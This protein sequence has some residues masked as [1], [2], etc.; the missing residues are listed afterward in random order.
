MFIQEADRSAGIKVVF[1]DHF[2]TDFLDRG[3]LVSFTGIMGTV[4]GQRVIYEDSE[5]T[6]DFSNREPLESLGMSNAAIQGWP[7]NPRQPSGPRWAGL[8]PLGLFV[9]VWGV[10]TSTGWA[11]EDGYYIYLDDGWGKKDGSEA[12]AT[13]IRVYSNFIPNQGDFLVASGI[14]STKVAYDPTPNGPSGDELI[15][16]IIRTTNDLGPYIPTYEP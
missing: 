5:F 14:L 4:G 9:K 11:D 16:P 1:V 6:Y 12:G 3:H 15:I 8:S 2:P 10:V 13:G 7:M